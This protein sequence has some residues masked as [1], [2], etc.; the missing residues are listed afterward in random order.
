[1][2]K[3][4]VLSEL[5]K[6]GSLLV[7]PGVNDALT[8]K[9]AYHCGASVIYMTGYGT[10]AVR[11]YPDVGLLTMS[12]MVDNV[13]RISDAVDLPLIADADT[14]YGNPVNVY[15]TVREYGRAGAAAI[16]IEDQTWPK[17]CGHMEG[18]TVIT[19]EEMV[20]K[21]KAAADAR[22]D[23][24]MLL[25]IR[26]DAIATHG[27]EEA[28]RRGRL[29]ADAGA[30]V[31]FIEAP[32]QRQMEKIPA[33]FSKPCMLNIPFPTRE[34]GLEDVRKMGYRIALFPLVTLIGTIAG[35]LRTCTALLRE[36]RQDDGGIPFD[37]QG[38]H[39]FLGLGCMKAMEE[40]YK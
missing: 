22:T 10:S 25:V 24:G 37:L 21:I 16:Q 30:D 14:G 2:L 38:L 6:R 11:G 27:F 26:S 34:I 8:A 15:R 3:A 33:A 18:K 39:Q 23:S 12:E 1:M 31:L 40:K 19:A 7:A 20:S 35:C 17:R 29:Y 28:V 36:G 9:I 5:L 13:W 32:D 4:Q